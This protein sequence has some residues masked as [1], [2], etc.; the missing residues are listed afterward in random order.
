MLSR[1]T[2]GCECD[3]GLFRTHHGEC[4]SW[5]SK[6]DNGLSRLANEKPENDLGVLA[7]I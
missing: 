3:P 4:K 1:D 7:T 5:W 2:Y 6:L